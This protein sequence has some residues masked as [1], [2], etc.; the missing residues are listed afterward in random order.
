MFIEF[1]E[2]IQNYQKGLEQDYLQALKVHGMFNQVM[3]E[4]REHSNIDIVT[5]IPEEY[6][7]Y[8]RNY[9]YWKGSSNTSYMIRDG[10]I[11]IYDTYSY[12]GKTYIK[13]LAAECFEEGRYK[14]W[15]ASYQ[16]S[17]NILQALDDKSHFIVDNGST[18]QDFKYVENRDEKWCIERAQKDTISHRRSI[19]QRVR[20]YIGEVVKVDKCPG[21][22]WYLLG[23]NGNK[24]HMYFIEAGGYNIQCLHIRCIVK[25][26]K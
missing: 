13:P 21:D 1:E 4:L 22:G 14:G 12:N 24:C 18:V 8:F 19:E 10:I 23:D 17:K 5:T 2:Y 26:V 6:R 20:K 11:A 7:K 3:K 25:P 9:S 15:R 16:A